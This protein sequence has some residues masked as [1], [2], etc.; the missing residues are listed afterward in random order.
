MYKFIYTV[1]Y[2]FWWRNHSRT[3]KPWFYQQH[4][5]L[6]NLN[7]GLQDRQQILQFFCHVAVQQGTRDSSPTRTCCDEISLGGVPPKKC[8]A[9][10]GRGTVGGRNPAN[11]LIGR[12]IMFNHVWVYSLQGFIHPRWCRMSS[13]H[14]RTDWNFEKSIGER[15]LYNIHY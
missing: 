9:M 13:I 5:F 14:C 3:G 15:H 8:W 6:S 1:Y 11:Q 12:L 4:F 7:L 2:F 10:Q